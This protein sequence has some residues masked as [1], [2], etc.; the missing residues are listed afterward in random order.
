[1][2]MVSYGAVAGDWYC[3]IETDAP[4]VSLPELKPFD[5]VLACN[6]LD[7]RK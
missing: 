2:A 7:V 6:L 5:T 4:P 3:I 1:M